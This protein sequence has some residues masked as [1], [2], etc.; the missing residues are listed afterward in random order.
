MNAEL[1]QVRA[2][3]GHS[4][5]VRRWLPE[6]GMQR[7]ALVHLAHG[8]AE[9]GG[10]YEPLAQALAASGYVVYAHDHRGH[11]G[12]VSRPEDRGWV[13]ESDTF[14]RL[15]RDLLGLAFEEQREHGGLPL[16]LFGHS[17]GSYVVQR[18]M[19]QEGSRLAGAILSGSGGKPSLLAS[20][21]RMLARVE[22][23]RLGARGKSPLIDAL[24]FQS[25]N[26]VFA[27]NRTAF[28]WLSRDPAQVDAYVADPNCGFLV[29]T[30]LWIDLLDELDR[31]AR[32]DEQT[33][34]PKELPVLVFSGADDPAGELGK[35]VQRLLDAYRR[36]G[37]RH[38]TSRLYGGGRHEMLN[39][40]NREEVLGDVL[41]WLDARLP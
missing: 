13:G 7:R 31:L 26:K 3:D 29:S 6:A 28:D 39:E 41:A 36:V 1:S 19:I 40:T 33:R 35:S 34:I 10:R 11:G 32:P 20:A 15:V 16:I 38:V 30:Q 2:D 22:R 12:S 18:C 14:A 21:G 23:A 27:P 8:M 25:F 37:L 24:S 5:Q 9:H 4:L 17:M